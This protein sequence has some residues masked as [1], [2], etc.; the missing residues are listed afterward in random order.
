MKILAGLRFTN[1]FAMDAYNNIFLCWT[2]M[3]FRGVHHSGAWEIPS[4]SR[5]PWMPNLGPGNICLLTCNWLL[6]V[7]LATETPFLWGMWQRLHLRIEKDCLLL[8][9]C[10]MTGNRMTTGGVSTRQNS[11]PIGWER[12]EK[13]LWCMT[14][15]QYCPLAAFSL[16]CMLHG[17]CSIGKWEKCLR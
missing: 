10:M 15:F 9:W 17:L 13:P 1:C 11:E 6:R 4:I 7:S 12:R 2:Y 16:A 3:G 5:K 8:V 14:R